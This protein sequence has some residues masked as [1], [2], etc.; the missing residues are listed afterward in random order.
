M[1]CLLRAIFTPVKHNSISRKLSLKQARKM[2][3][4]TS[5]RPSTSVSSSASGTSDEKMR[6]FKE[7]FEKNSKK[8]RYPTKVDIADNL[9]YGRGVRATQDMKVGATQHRFALKQSRSDMVV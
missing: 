4:P 8:I 6:R 1:W 9:T 5:T 2:E 3:A 7:W